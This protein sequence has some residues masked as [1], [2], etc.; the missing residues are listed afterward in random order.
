MKKNKNSSFFKYVEPTKVLLF[1]YF[2]YIVF[3]W[4]LLSIPFSGKTAVSFLDHLFTCVSAVSTTG[5]TTV[6]VIDS[7]SLMGQI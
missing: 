4:F 3:G 5:L 2:T 1:G 6:S 7:Y